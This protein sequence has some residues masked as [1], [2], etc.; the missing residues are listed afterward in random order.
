MMTA[1]GYGQPMM[2]G[3]MPQQPPQQPQPMQQQQQPPQQQQIP[4]PQPTQQQQQQHSVQQQDDFGLKVKRSF[5]NFDT[6]LK[7]ELLFQIKLILSIGFL[8]IFT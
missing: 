2:H 4:P 8:D 1:Q 7:V 3:M 5:T 6:N